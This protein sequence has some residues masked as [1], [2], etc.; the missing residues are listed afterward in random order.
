M[1]NILVVDDNPGTLLS[2]ATIL[3]LQAHQVT[4]TS[5]GLE[6]LVTIEREH[7]GLDLVLTDLRLPDISGFEVLVGAVIRGCR[8]V[9]YTAFDTQPETGI[10]ARHLGAVAFVDRVLDE[11]DLI[12]VVRSSLA[13]R[14]EPSSVRAGVRESADH[15]F[16][17]GFDAQEVDSGRTLRPGHAASR[18]ASIVVAVTRLISDVPTIADW[19]RHIGA[20]PSTLKRWCELVHVEAGDSLDFARLLRVVCQHPGRRIDWFDE[21][22]IV[23]PRTLKRLL[24]RA[25]LS[26]EEPIP[27]LRV[28]LAR[29]RF[30]ASPRL[31]AAVWHILDL[32]TP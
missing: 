25:S 29:Q 4:T 1:A 3:R 8:G 26:D 20:S 31:Q 15:V 22:A 2:Y 21:L 27:D 17:P 13:V 32:R 5:T 9:V 10:L 24:Q 6:G 28:Y 30:V 12:Q 23:T 19:G 16:P 18:W 14:A 7:R 11:D